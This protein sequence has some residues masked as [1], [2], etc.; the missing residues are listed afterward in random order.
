V[1]P[2]ASTA[3]LLTDD[4]NPVDLLRDQDAQDWRERTIKAIGEKAVF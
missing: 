1:T 2:D 3:T 4:H